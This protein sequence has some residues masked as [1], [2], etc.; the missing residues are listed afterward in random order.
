MIL[1][2]KE[3]TL[4]RILTHAI[5]FINEKATTYPELKQKLIIDHAKGF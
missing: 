1:I 2:T 4:N 5:D 3:K